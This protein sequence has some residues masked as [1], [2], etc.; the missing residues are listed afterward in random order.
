MTWR[1]E[2]SSQYTS[3]TTGSQPR[4][5]TQQDSTNKSNQSAYHLLAFKKSIKR[6]VSQYTIPKDEKY[7]ETSERTLLVTATTHDCE[8]I[9]DGNSKPENTRDSQELFNKRSISC[10]VFS[11]GIP[12]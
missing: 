11:N 9:L 5:Y 8:E 2:Y 10:T 4:G 6:E 1:L 7:F 12:K 3:P